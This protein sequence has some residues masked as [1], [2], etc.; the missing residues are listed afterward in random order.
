MTCADATHPVTVAHLGVQPSN[1]MGGV[2][3]ATDPDS[4]M[5]YD[6]KAEAL[7]AAAAHLRWPG[8]TTITAARKHRAAWVARVATLRPEETP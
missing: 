7:A 1:G 5:R 3:L 2:T 8:A 6:S 4:A